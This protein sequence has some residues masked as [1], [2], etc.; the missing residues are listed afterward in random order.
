M[1]LKG[2]VKGKPI[3]A[4]IDSESTHSFVD[5]KTAGDLKLELTWVASMIVA[6]ADGQKL[7]VKPK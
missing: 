7:I 3:F 1:K 6:V 4:L 5:S 2:Q